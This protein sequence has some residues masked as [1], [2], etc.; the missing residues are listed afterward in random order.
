[1]ESFGLDKEGKHVQFFG[2][3]CDTSQR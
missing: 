2:L 3:D 1:L